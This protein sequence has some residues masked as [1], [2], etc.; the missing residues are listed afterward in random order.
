VAD[1]PAKGKCFRSDR[2][3][4]HVVTFIGD[5][6]GRGQD[7]A[8]E[9][10]VMPV[11]MSARL[12]V[13]LALGL[14][15]AAPASAGTE[16]SV[17]RLVADGKILPLET[18]RKRVQSQVRGDYIGAEWDEVTWTYRL[19]FVDNGN[20]INVDVD[21]RTGQRVRRTANY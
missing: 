16:N 8:R 7:S 9:S 2:I 13:L 15:V 6:L 21:A 12:S 5:S 11:S 17:M 20:V 19:R 1:K 3:L 10:E 14:A 4:A 18:I